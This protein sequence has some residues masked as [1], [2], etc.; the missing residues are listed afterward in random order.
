MDYLRLL[1]SADNVQEVHTGAPII[2][3]VSALA[4]LIQTGRIHTAHTKRLLPWGSP[5]IVMGKM[6][7]KAPLARLPEQRDKLSCGVR[8][9]ASGEGLHTSPSQFPFLPL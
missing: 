4:R 1:S 2:N 6:T 3:R 5:A 8:L 7:T 9:Q